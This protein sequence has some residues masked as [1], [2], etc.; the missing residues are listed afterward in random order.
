MKWGLWS[1]T[2]ASN[3][4]TPPDGW[5]E[6]QLPSTVND[7]AR[8][9]MAQ[10]KTGIS[11]IQFVDLGV[12][13]T[14]T[15]NTTFTLA[16]NQMQW[17]AWGTRVKA[18]VGGTN[19]YGTVI[20][21]SFTTNTGVTMRLDGPN[22]PFL[23]GSLSAVSTGF[24]GPVSG[25]INEQ[26]WRRRNYALNGCMD[27]FQRSSGSSK[28]S[29]AFSP[30]YTLDGWGIT[31][32][33]TAG[34]ALRV[35]QY[36]A[37]LPTVA[38]AGC[39]INNAYGVSCSAALGTVNAGSYLYLY[40]KIEGYDFRMLAQKPITVSFWVISDET[41]T[42]ACALQNSGLDRSIVLNFSISSVAAWEKKTLTFP[43]SPAAGTWNYTNGN[44]LMVAFPLVAGSSV[45]GGA[46]NWT[47]ANILATSSNVNF[48]RSAGNT[49]AIT[50]VQIEEGNFASPLEP[51]NY[52]D[53]LV[54]CRRRLYVL[55]GST[56]RMFGHA[57]ASNEGVY[58]GIGQDVAMRTLNPSLSVIAAL[59]SWIMTTGA[60]A[61]QSVSAISLLNNT[62]NSFALLAFTVGGGSMTTG[63]GSMLFLSGAPAVALI[64]K[65]EI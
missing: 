16:G 19:L 62:F 17:Y 10:I 28:F 43:K 48:M 9:M 15:G 31:G 38:Q 4:S 65:A 42:Y 23:T 36:T 8:E 53:E 2:A 40:Q 33:L 63:Q 55:A 46:G 24:P 20:S 34:A 7:C 37:S 61:A 49:F 14:Q 29:S 35:T 54:R 60:G 51:P 44:G 32:S 27:I 58:A 3:S 45:Q 25:A 6:G 12:T 57:L 22:G 21:S 52:T 64:L 26:V 11:D 18:N 41:G 50:G 39:L 47:A 59:T 5:P 30:T 1:T 56:P 13:P